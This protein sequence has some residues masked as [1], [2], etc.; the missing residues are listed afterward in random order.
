MC[1]GPPWHVSGG[2]KMDSFVEAILSFYFY[3]DSETQTQ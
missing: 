1:V 3:M 2:Q